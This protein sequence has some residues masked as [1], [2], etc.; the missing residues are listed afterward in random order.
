MICVIFYRHSAVMM[1]YT[2]VP[3]VTAVLLQLACALEVMTCWSP[4]L[5]LETK[6]RL[7]L[8]S[9]NMWIQEMFI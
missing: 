3:M 6:G 8:R 2:A 4:A 5:C 9:L 1:E 7:N